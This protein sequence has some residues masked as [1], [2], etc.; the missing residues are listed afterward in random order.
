MSVRIA[1]LEDVLDHHVNW[2]ED[3][4]DCLDRILPE[5]TDAYDQGFRDGLKT[6]AE[7]FRGAWVDVTLRGTWKRNSIKVRHNPNIYDHEV[8]DRGNTEG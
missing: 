7:V 6:A 5:P 3:Q 2:L 8:M 4:V 1:R